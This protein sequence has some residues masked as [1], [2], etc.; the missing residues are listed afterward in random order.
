MRDDKSWYPWWSGLAF[1][2]SSLL[3]VSHDFRGGA[4]PIKLRLPRDNPQPR[5]SSNPTAIA[6]QICEYHGASVWRRLGGR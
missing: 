5:H 1:D 6:R 3:S 2:A 4:G